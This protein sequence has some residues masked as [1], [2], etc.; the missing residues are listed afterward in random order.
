MHTFA[1]QHRGLGGWNDE[2]PFVTAFIDLREGVRMMTVLRGV[3]AGEPASIAIGAP[4]R[5]EFERA[6]EGVFVPFWRVV[7][8]PPP[9]APSPGEAGC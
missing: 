5:V 6:A 8:P 1:V 3:D 2:T 7:E 4:V 9:A